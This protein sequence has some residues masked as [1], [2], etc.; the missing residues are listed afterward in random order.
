MHKVLSREY[1]RPK[2]LVIRGGREEWITMDGDSCAAPHC[3]EAPAVTF[4][5]REDPGR[6]LHACG[7]FG[8]QVEVR[9]LVAQMAAG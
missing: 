1:Q 5:L 7:N 4:Y 9:Q 8:H 2:K 3:L 6:G